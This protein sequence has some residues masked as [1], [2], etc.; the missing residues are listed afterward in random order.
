MSLKRILSGVILACL[1]LTLSPAAVF[2]VDDEYSAATEGELRAAVEALNKN[3][4]EI[5][6]RL[7][8]DIEMTS[9][10]YLNVS[11]GTLT[12]LG[13]GK[14]ICFSSRAISISGDAVVNLGA[15]DYRESLTLVSNDDTN[16]VIFIGSEATLNMYDAVSI[17]DSTSAGTA[18]GVQV[19]D[20]G[21]FNMYG[22]AIQN[23]H[24][25]YSVAGGVYIDGNAKFNMYDGLIDNCSGVHGGAV[26]VSGAAPIGPVVNGSAAFHMYGGEIKNSVDKYLGGGGICAYTV[27]PI[28]I[29][30][31]GGKITG[32]SGIGSGGKYGYGG[33]VFIYTTSE[34]ALVQINA[35]EISGN[36]A[37]IGG[38][39][40][41]YA[42]NVS[43]ADGVKLYNN[44]ATVGGDD[45][46][47]NGA[48]V[49]LGQVAGGL[50]LA[51]CGQAID[52]W[53]YDDEPR[54]STSECDETASDSMRPY[55][56]TGIADTTEYGLKAA[57]GVLPVEYR[58]EFYYDNQIDESLSISDRGAEGTVITADKLIGEHEVKVGYV[59]DHADQA[60]LTLTKGQENVIKL[61]F[62]TETK[63]DYTIQYYLDGKLEASFT[64]TGASASAQ[65]SEIPDK[66]P[67]GYEKG[68]VEYGPIVQPAE[69]KPGRFTVE[70]YYT[71]IVTYTVT[72]TDGV[73]D[74]VIFEDKTFGQLKNGDKT[75]AFGEEP[76][77]Q[78]YTFAGWT[79]SVSETISGDA[80]Y[81]ATW[82]AIPVVDDPD[83]PE[84]PTEPTES[85]EPTEPDTEP[86][87]P[88]KLPESE[89]TEPESGDT[90]KE[91]PKTG[92][93]PFVS[94]WITLLLISGCA[95]TGL[96]IYLTKRANHS[97]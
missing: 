69:G 89:N 31:D 16:P 53:Y 82:T 18:A 51:P 11:K 84:L 95:A 9:G 66:C 36:Q 50:T 15:S 42:G 12:I 76:V 33:A 22:G 29:I 56:K 35:G 8:D 91:A 52:G 34:D 77:R 43:V 78:G 45:I 13:E 30:I 88:E 47:N 58:A 79:P 71:K 20:K 73:D 17:Q 68:K 93:D 27:Q 37:V 21:T 1:V 25:P 86:S 90:Q 59:F 49:T 48:N 28:S 65:L 5:T 72:Y 83:D 10:S 26:G 81:T 70:V 24:N 38:G 55:T 6:V 60:S 2:A 44:T 87:K 67:E 85:P 61:Y 40:F 96:N 80:A 57:H 92:S 97:R 74:E 46:Y 32:C 7:T 75:P 3:G 4:G 39:M 64:E 62:K 63:Y 94:L 41:V 14:T 54:Y 19:N 23:C